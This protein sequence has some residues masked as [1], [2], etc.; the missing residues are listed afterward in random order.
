MADRDCG[1]VL[2]IDIQIVI[3]DVVDQIAAGYDLLQVHR[4]TSGESGP[5]VEI[6][7]EST[8]VELDSTKTIYDYSDQTGS[9]DYWYKFRLYNSTTLAVSAFSTAQPG[10]LDPAL[11]V[12]S[13]DELKTNYLFG[14]DLTD[15]AGNPYPDSLYAHFIK[16]AVRWM[17]S[18]LDIP[19][20]RT[21]IEEEKHD[22]FF[23]D[24]GKFMLLKL[25]RHPVISVESVRLV[26]PGNQEVHNF[27]KDWISLQRFEGH[28]NIVPGPAGSG[29]IALGFNSW[30]FPWMHR[31]TSKW[32][33]DV[34]RVA[35][36]AGFGRRPEGSWNFP[37]GSEPASVSH[38]D[39]EL[40]SLPVD[41]KELVGKVASFGPLNIAGDL[42]GGAGIAS[43]SISIDGLSQS[44]NTTSSST[45]SGY[46]ARLITYRQEIK[47]WIPTLIKRYHGVKTMVV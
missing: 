22:F 30:F 15:D 11:S 6:T 46:G 7:T 43:Q 35:Y 10:E 5:Y 42:L 27:S 28:V 44:F 34:F 47:D 23:E 17:E 4:S 9:P 24:W 33:P 13:I 36:T 31:A 3:D 12:L 29:T 32:I 40:D 39:P 26:M 18:K 8:R 16:A 37:R 45:S 25:A 14:L 21:V 2:P 1:L 41:I 20:K 19:I 38:P